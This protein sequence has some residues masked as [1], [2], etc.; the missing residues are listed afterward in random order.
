[1]KSCILISSI[2]LFFGCGVKGK[3]QVPDRLPMIGRGQLDQTQVIEYQ[4]KKVPQNNVEVPHQVD[5][6][7]SSNVKEPLINKILK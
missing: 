1:M 6:T 5:Q 7:S 2:L 3:P 4:K